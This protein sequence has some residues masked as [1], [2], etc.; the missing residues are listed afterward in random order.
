MVRA[1]AGQPGGRSTEPC[2][3]SK[4]LYY[5]ELYVA[6][7]VAGMGTPPEV[8]D[9]RVERWISATAG[10]QNIALSDEQAAAVQG[11]ACSAFSI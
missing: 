3:Y 8:D 4:S 1:A 5:D 9:A 7:K 2:Y 6:R 11:I 10:R